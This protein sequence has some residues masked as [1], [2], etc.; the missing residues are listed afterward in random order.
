M[1]MCTRL[2][3]SYPRNPMCY[4]LL[5]NLYQISIL[6]RSTGC[7]AP[8]EPAFSADVLDGIL[9]VISRL[10]QIVVTEKT[11]YIREH[12]LHIPLPRQQ[13]TQTTVFYE[14]SPAL[15]PPP[16]QHKTPA[17]PPTPANQHIDPCSIAPIRHRMITSSNQ[18]PRALHVNSL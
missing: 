12:I 4:L 9:C 11:F 7:R 16:I 5:Q 1:G 2:Y 6:C 14:P 17:N 8:N 15:P 18:C 13:Q 10:Y 3:S